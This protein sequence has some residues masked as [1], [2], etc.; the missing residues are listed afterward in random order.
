MA[1]VMG[2]RVAGFVSGFAGLGLTF[3]LGLVPLSSA[4]SARSHARDLSGIWNNS[5]ITPLERPRE[6]G[7]KAFFTA[8]EAAEFENNANRDLNRDR[9]DG[10]ADADVARAYNEAWFDRAPK[11]CRATGPR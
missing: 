3:G 5:T 11:P 6:L 8:A 7:T 4:Q 1:F 9:R 2:I 10:P